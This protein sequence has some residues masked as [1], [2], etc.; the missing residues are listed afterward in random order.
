MFVGLHQVN[1][2][3]PDGILAGITEPIYLSVLVRQGCL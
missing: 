2:V 3:V 1:V